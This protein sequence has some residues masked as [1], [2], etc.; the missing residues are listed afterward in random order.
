[1]KKNTAHFIILPLLSFFFLLSLCVSAA[2]S[3]NIIPE[4]SGGGSCGA[5]KNNCG[6]YTLDDFMVL[7]VNISNWVLGIVGSVTLL[8]FIYGGFMFVLSGGSEE[9]VKNGKSILLNSI[10]GL[11]IV[12]TSFLIIQFIMSSLGF[13]KGADGTWSKLKDAT[14]WENPQK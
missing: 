6:D 13:V 4:P 2:Y 14:S 10:I 12:F 5:S 9:R 7:A 3:A 8:F 1:M 11:V